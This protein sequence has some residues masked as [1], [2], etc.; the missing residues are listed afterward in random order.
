[1]VSLLSSSQQITAAG[2]GGSCPSQ[3]PCTQRS[4][5]EAGSKVLLAYTGLRKCSLW[6]CKMDAVATLQSV[7]SRQ[8]QMPFPPR[9]SA[10]ATSITIS[11]PSLSD[12]PL[13][14]FI[15]SQG[16]IVPPVEP[17]TEAS[18]FAVLDKNK[19]V[20]YIG[21]SKDLR[22]SLRILMGRRP[23]FCYF[24]KMFNL[25]S[26]DQETMLEARNQWMSELGVAPEGNADRTQRM[27]WEQ[28][29]DAGSISERGKVAAA[30]AKAKTMLQMFTDRGITEE[31]V[32]DPK[33]LEEGKCDI[34]PTKQSQ[35][36]LDQATGSQEEDSLKSKAVSINRPSGG[37]ID[38]DITYEMKFKTNGG[39]MYDIA[40]TKDDTLTRHRVIV[41]RMFPEA[42]SMPE[43]DFLEIIMGFLLYK[44][45]P[46]HTEGLL[47]PCTFPVNYFAISQVAQFFNDLNDW[48]PSK[49]PDNFWR[50]MRTE[51][52]GPAIDPPPELGPEEKVSI[53][54]DKQ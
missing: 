1:M 21:F 5:A 9:A 32:Y 43:D 52:Y 30:K 46:R 23:E 28:P 41:G 26:L 33:L 2:A 12:L 35:A 42:V 7:S 24:Y 49:L 15:N 25:S 19:K 44:K 50:F 18:V 31:M 34:L 16:R 54:A 51:L 45:I 38:Y 3:L 47:D 20:Q 36:D 40:I 13:N 39:W 22:N 11:I 27:F 4:P 14:N 6:V 17:N 10:A 48:F 53:Y 37:T 29:V 8:K